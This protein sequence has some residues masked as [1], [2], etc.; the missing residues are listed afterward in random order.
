MLIP[1]SFAVVVLV[2]CMV[3]R[4]GPATCVTDEVVALRAR[5]KIQSVDELSLI[6]DQCD[7]QIAQLISK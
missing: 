5:L 2:V 7:L 1:I 6:F 3:L 4:P